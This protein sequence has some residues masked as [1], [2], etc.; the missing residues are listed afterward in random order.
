MSHELSA[1]LLTAF[2]FGKHKG[3]PVAEVVK[4]NPEYVIWFQDNITKYRVAAH[5][6]EEAKELDYNTYEGY[7]IGFPDPFTD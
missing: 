5:L 7:D 2:P 4:I 3:K 1:E 6:Y